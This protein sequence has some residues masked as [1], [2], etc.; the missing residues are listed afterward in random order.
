[1]TDIGPGDRELSSIL[2]QSSVDGLFAVDR[3]SRYVLWNAA[4]ERFAG[5]PAGEVLGRHVFD[6][7]P[8]LRDLG[9]DHALERALAGE[10]VRSERFPNVLPSGETHYFDRIY[11]PL[12]NH[13][14]GIVGVQGVVR[15]VTER[16]LAEEALRASEAKLRLAVAA[17]GVGLWSWD[18]EG[19]DVVWEDALCVIFGLPPGAFPK[20]RGEYLALIHPE[21]RERVQRIIRRGIEAGGWENEHRI[22]RGDGAVR[23]VISKGAVSRADGGPVA[24]GAVIDVTE[25]HQ[26]EEQARQTQKLEAVGQLT[27]GVAHNF[28]NLL[29]AMTANLELAIRQA[30]VQIAPLLR[31][32]E[33]AALRAADLVRQ[34]MTFAGRNRPSP[35]MRVE[36]VGSLV[37]R[38]VGFCRTTLDRRIALHEQYDESLRARVDALQLEQAVLNILINA[39][40]ALTDPR[41]CDPRITIT[42]DAVPAGEAEQRGREDEHV[43]IRVTD[44]GPGMDSATLARVFEPFFTT[45]DIGKG[46]GLGL[47]TTHAIVREHGGF[48]ACDSA[49]G[50]GAS[51]SVYLARVQEESPARD[52]FG[53]SARDARGGT[54]TLLVVDDEPAVRTVVARLLESVGYAVRQAASGGEAIELLTDAEAASKVSLVLLDISMPGISGRQLRQRL[55]ELAPHVRVAYFT[56]YAHD[57]VE[58]EDVVI[59]KPVSFQRLVDTVRS[60]LDRPA[61]QLAPVT[62]THGAA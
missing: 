46:T 41:V 23:W 4:M 10:T 59:E 16:S 18:I 20:T 40:D 49:P 54:E 15:D 38:T 56:G 26:R 3:Q 32:V 24:N 42:V 5:K 17:A 13:A 44:N 29:M 14:G 53:S 27:A 33:G 50:R 34:L 61:G 30:P 31:D 6:V 58:S 25:R 35:A 22:V 19:D 8:F 36:P 51:F 37:A 2:V 9:L 11:M 62:S 60:V 7:F 57:A 39:R 12:L 28:N 21:D 45:K 43:R 1:M 52:A 55:V 47:A 48:I